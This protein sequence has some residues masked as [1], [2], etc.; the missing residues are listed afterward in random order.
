[1]KIDLSVPYDRRIDIRVYDI[2]GNEIDVI[3][4]KEIYKQGIYTITWSGDTHPSGVY[5]IKLDDGEDIRI[6]KMVLAR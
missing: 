1:M 6:R 3:S 4:N 5:V 2:L